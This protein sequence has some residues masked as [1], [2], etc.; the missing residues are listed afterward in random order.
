MKKK[1]FLT[2]LIGRNLERILVS[3]DVGDFEKTQIEEDISFLPLEVSSLKA[4]GL[5]EI[6]NSLIWIL[7]YGLDVLNL[8]K[9]VM[10]ITKY[11]RIHC[12]FQLDIL[13][14]QDP[15]K[16]KKHLMG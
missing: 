11:S 9:I 16:S 5:V 6:S 2:Y 1:F 12:M 8:L 7:L 13:L 10:K 3:E 15:R 14:K 4:K